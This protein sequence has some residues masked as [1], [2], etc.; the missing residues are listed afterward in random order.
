M[1]SKFLILLGILAL[2]LVFSFGFAACED[3][4]EAC[5]TADTMRALATAD[6]PEKQTAALA[7][8]PSCCKEAFLAVEET[9]DYGC[10]KDAA[11]SLSKELG[12]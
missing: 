1:K 9:G 6:T 4:E 11:E 5:C 7:N 8:L 12:E 2:A 3:E 10:C